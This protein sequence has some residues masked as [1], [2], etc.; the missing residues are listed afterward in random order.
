MVLLELL[1]SINEPIK[2]WVFFIWIQDGLLYS[3]WG[4]NYQAQE[5][6]QSLTQV[7]SKPPAEET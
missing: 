6:S 2:F 1:V 3:P 7:A 4:M 5:E